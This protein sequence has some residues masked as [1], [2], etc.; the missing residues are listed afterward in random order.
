[1]KKG[2]ESQFKKAIKKYV[3]TFHNKDL[4]DEFQTQLHKKFAK[5]MKYVFLIALILFIVFYPL[6][7]NSYLKEKDDDK[8]KK[9]TKETNKSSLICLPL[10]LVTLFIEMIVANC[11]P[12][13]R[14]FRLFF[15]SLSM[16]VSTI[17]LLSIYEDSFGSSFL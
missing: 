12:I 10:F 4:E 16:N 15:F 7:I 14:R 1:M 6:F 3:L 11:F 2:R 9:T 8:V 13:F 17:L 5:Y